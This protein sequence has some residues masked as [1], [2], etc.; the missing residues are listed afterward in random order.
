[1]TVSL[2]PFPWDET[3]AELEAAT[4]GSER[5]MLLLGRLAT[6]IKARPGQRLWDQTRYK[7]LVRLYPIL[8][9]ADVNFSMYRGGLPE[10]G[11]TLYGYRQKVWKFIERHL[12]FSGVIA[13][14][15]L[16]HLTRLW[17]K[18]RKGGGRES[19]LS[20]FGG[21]PNYVRSVKANLKE[22]TEARNDQS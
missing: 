4:P 15:Q 8:K 9:Q 17:Y 20:F 1:M 22:K 2:R 6:E 7:A 14:P 21:L 18:H 11:L 3:V 12:P 13:L 10:T 16:W 19:F 5:Y